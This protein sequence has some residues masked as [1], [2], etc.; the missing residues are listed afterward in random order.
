MVEDLEI[1]PGIYFLMT[2]DPEIMPGIYF[3]VA[4][5]PQ[6]IPDIYTLMTDELRDMQGMEGIPKRIKTDGNKYKYR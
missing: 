3:L 2:E 1:I 4:E 5:G 6:I